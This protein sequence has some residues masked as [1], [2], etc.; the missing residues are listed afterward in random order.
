MKRLILVRHGETEWNAN[1]VLQG[2]A[3]IELSDKGQAQ[4]RALAAIVARWKIDRAVCSDLKRTRQTSALLGHAH[5][6]TDAT[7]READLG[8][9][10]GRDANELMKTSGDHYRAWRE[11]RQG[12]PGGED[13]A[14]FSQRIGRALAPLHE[15]DGTVLVVTHGGAIRAALALLINLTPE[16]II[17]VHPGSLTMIEFDTAPRLSL[18]NVTADLMGRETTE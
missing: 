17:A 18:Y 16:R 13:F 9:W 7:W 2:Q 1:S 5:A 15:I 3:D 6:H 10:T 4:A 8:E 14:T 12:P 11:G